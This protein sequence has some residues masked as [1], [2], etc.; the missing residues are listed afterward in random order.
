MP[1]IED[2]KILHSRFKSNTTTIE[3][4]SIPTQ[5][6]TN[7]SKVLEALTAPYHKNVVI[8]KI[9][10]PSGQETGSIKVANGLQM[11]SNQV[12]KQVATQIEMGSN[13]V[14]KKTPSDETGSK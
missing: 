13:Q 14:A 12:A 5:D 6:P 2:F 1:N 8:K 7:L 4:N 9:G 10:K 3:K 11:G